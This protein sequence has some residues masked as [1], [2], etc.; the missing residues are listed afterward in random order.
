[1]EKLEI[2]KNL[3]NLEEKEECALK[4][5]LV[6][7]C[8]NKFFSIYF[9]GKQTKGI[10]APDLVKRR[11]ILQIEGRCSNCGQEISIY[12]S[13]SRV[14]L[15]KKSKILSKNSDE[16]SLIRFGVSP[17]K[18]KLMYNYYQ[19]K[20]K[21]DEYEMILIDVFDIRKNKWKRIVEE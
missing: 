11:G 6:C 15:K 21:T 20:Y 19:E 12:N 17:Y 1:M 9:N 2:L 10:L 3:C 14:T 5:D 7:L 4:G 8:G 13:L 16:Q 18:I